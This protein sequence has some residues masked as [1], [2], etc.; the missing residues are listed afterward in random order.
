MCVCST[1]IKLGFDQGEKGGR[2]TRTETVSVSVSV[3][4]D[5]D[6]DDVLVLE[7]CLAGFLK[8]KMATYV[9]T[10]G[11]LFIFGHEILYI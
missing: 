4:K 11:G 9:I 3:R 8:A 2:P 10:Y 7:N 5:D 6:D 1:P